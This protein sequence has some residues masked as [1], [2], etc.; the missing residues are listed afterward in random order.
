MWPCWRLVQR[1]KA[2]LHELR[3]VYS[4]EDVMSMNDLLDATDEAEA[5]QRAKTAVTT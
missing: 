2:S 4:R 3:T 5:E 1:G